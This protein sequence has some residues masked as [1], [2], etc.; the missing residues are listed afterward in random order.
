MSASFYSNIS[1]RYVFLEKC[2]G[3]TAAPS[4]ALMQLGE[5]QE[6]DFSILHYQMVRYFYELF[7]ISL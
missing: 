6:S 2:F 7:L 5:G 1:Y 3:A 4:I